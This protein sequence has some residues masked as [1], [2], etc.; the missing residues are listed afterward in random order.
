MAAK[1]ERIG[2]ENADLFVCKVG[3]ARKEPRT[4]CVP[5]RKGKSRDPGAVEVGLQ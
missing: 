4:Q 5:A 1:T 3:V 2:K